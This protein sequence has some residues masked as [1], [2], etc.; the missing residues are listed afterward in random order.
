MPAVIHGVLSRPAL[1]KPTAL[2][3]LPRPSIEA[4][5]KLKT[6]E[7]HLGECLQE[8]AGRPGEVNG[9]LLGSL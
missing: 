2:S 1:S 3:W 6:N 5:E 8:L 4:A 7:M 9:L